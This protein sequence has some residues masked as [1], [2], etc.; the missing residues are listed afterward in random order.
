MTRTAALPAS[1][2]GRVLTYDF[3]FDAS[4]NGQ[5]LKRLTIV[6]EYTAE[7]LAIDVAGS[8]LRMVRTNSHRSRPRPADPTGIEYSDFSGPPNSDPLQHGL[9]FPTYTMT[10]LGYIA[11]IG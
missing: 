9:V 2:I 7:C 3:V 6:D 8:I 11:V 5:Q 4:V 1:G 10:T